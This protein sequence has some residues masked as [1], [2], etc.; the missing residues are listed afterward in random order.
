VAIFGVGSMWEKEEL[1]EQFFSEGKF[2]LGWNE[3]SAKDLYAFVGSFRVGDILYIKASA[4]G[5]RTIR[6]KGIGIVTR[7]FMGCVNVGD[8]GGSSIREWQSLFVRVAWVCTEEF[9]IVIPENEGKLTN[10]RAATMYEEFLP[11]VQEA[12]VAKLLSLIH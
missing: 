6:V 8:L 2:I 4:P 12:V 5:S 7:D 3:D 1:K 10:I 11:M 9:T